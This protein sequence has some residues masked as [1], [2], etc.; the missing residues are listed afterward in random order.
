M[1]IGAIAESVRERL[2]VMLRI[3]PR[4]LLE[5]HA[6]L[7]LAQSMMVGTKVG[8]FEALA[9]TP[10]TPAELAT[11]CGLDARATGALA[12]VLAATDYLRGRADGRYELTNDARTWLLA[13][14]PRSLADNLRFRFIECDWI[15][16][17]EGFVR[18]GRPLDIHNE[19]IPAQW[20]LYQRGMRA[21]AT[22]Q[23]REVTWR[24]PIPRHARTLLDIGGAHGLFAVALC[25]HHPR[26]RATILDLPEAVAWAAPLL[27]REGMGDRVVHQAGDALDAELGSDCY[28]VIFI[29]NVL[30][31]F[32]AEQSQ[33]LI[34]RAAHALRPRGVLV[35]QEL[36]ALP[37]TRRPGQVAALADLYF[38]LTSEAG[39]LSVDQLAAWQKA[40]GLRPRRPLRFVSFPGA[41]QQS[42]V[43]PK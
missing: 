18:S 17:L 20:D 43:K 2:A 29:A 14:S 12:R 8:L 36:F 11:R 28:D 38:A 27:A 40:A 10:L 30:H 23:A 5:T 24:T 34:E 32:K 25:R 3:G 31:H 19:M 4:P 15:A 41:G 7:L 22:V 37:T 1:R 35:I 6:T 42:A 13:D 26:L 39:T 33:G 16:R 21:L 9:E